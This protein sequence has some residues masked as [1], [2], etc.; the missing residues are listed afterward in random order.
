MNDSIW[1]YK[2]GQFKEYIKTIA[3]KTMTVSD[4]LGTFR[5]LIIMSTI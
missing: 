4:A 1:Y 3:D 5:E 2:L